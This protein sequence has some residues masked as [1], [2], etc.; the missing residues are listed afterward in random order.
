LLFCDSV[1]WSV[2]RLT[3]TLNLTCRVTCPF[4]VSV[5]AQIDMRSREMLSRI[6]LFG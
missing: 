3:R 2:A 1:F 6:D 4:G 5:H